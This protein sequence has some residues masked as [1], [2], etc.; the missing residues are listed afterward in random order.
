MKIYIRLLLFVSLLY[1]NSY[2]RYI[3]TTDE[4]FI[5][6]MQQEAID[7]NDDTVLVKYSDLTSCETQCRKTNECVAVDNKISKLLSNI[8][9]S[10]TEA[11]RTEFESINSSKTLIGLK[12]NTSNGT[13]AIPL[14]N[15]NGSQFT[16]PNQI[17]TQT[18]YNENSIIIK[19]EKANVYHYKVES[20]FSGTTITS[21][22]IENIKN[23][24]NSRITNSLGV[25]GFEINGEKII[26]NTPINNNSFKWSTSDDEI[27]VIDNN[28]NGYNLQ[29]ITDTN[30]GN[31]QYYIKYK[32]ANVQKNAFKNIQSDIKLIYRVY[33]DNPEYRIYVQ[34]TDKIYKQT[35]K[36]TS[37]LSGAVLQNEQLGFTG[38]YSLNG[39]TCPLF[40]ANT[41]IGGDVDTNIFSSTS[42]CN[43]NCFIQEACSSWTEN[44]KCIPTSFDKSHPV[45]DYTGKTIFTKYNISWDCDK[46][47][48]ISGECLESKTVVS[49]ANTNFDTS[50]IG[51][52]SEKFENS[53]ESLTKI[54]S[55]EQ[56][57][58][59]WSGWAGYCEDG[60]MID[61]SWM[62]DPVTIL[63]MAMMAYT[64]AL[65][66]GYGE[67][68]KAGAESVNSVFETAET[69]SKVAEGASN[70]SDVANAGKVVSSGFFNETLYEATSIGL[71]ISNGQALIAAASIAAAAMA[72]PV[73]DDMAMAND[74][75]MAQMGGNAKSM[76]AINFVQ[77]M[78]S[79]GLSY[80]NLMAYSINSSEVSMELKEPWEN[81]ISLSEEQLAGL[82]HATHENFV[83][84]SFLLESTDTS[85][86]ISIFTVTS[87]LAYQQAGQVICGNGRIAL[88]MNIS[89]QSGD[90]GGSAGQAMAMAAAG[91]AVSM[92]PPPWNLAGA[93]LLKVLESVSDGDACKDSDLAT[94]W[95]IE[96]FKTNKAIK[97]SQ[98]RYIK[99][100]CEEK[101]RW[102][103]CMRKRNHFC[104]YDQEMSRIFVEGA[105]VQLDKPWVKG[106]CDDISISD[107]KNISF[108]KCL[109]EEDPVVDQCFPS[110]SWDALN[111]AIK[112]Q[113][114]KGFDA[115]SL[116]NTAIDSMPV[117]EDP[118]G[119][120]E[121]D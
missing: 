77:C 16:F 87:G 21:L 119:E 23:T 29:L 51:W 106:G 95:G 58:R 61:N 9:T 74:Y 18:V 49:S 52:K 90:G 92:L 33:K 82:I 88:A 48:T 114:I 10:L 30:A 8:S 32:Y 55:S 72:D 105:K 103:A 96:Q 11:K 97:G 35:T 22:D 44:S 111:T 70:A 102:G 64:G 6:W 121:G 110:Y 112:K 83:R 50:S 31:T 28:S 76:A 20:L 91:A 53:D 43:D 65:Q 13:V 62:S 109:T 66:G 26:I 7:V 89:A 47:E 94:K 41:D 60:L 71:K 5:Q 93:V 85:T 2:G 19:T 104:C 108:R 3:C 57:G 54:V 39:S 38:I 79:I 17:G 40:D 73:D 120:R 27:T 14:N 46:S 113:T 1:I 15:F 107:L 63:S 80:P 36:W 56:M 116:T 98:C 37:L 118:W 59:V 115:E 67:T 84:G 25:V 86:G 24:V 12:I 81:S 42:T 4:P 69:G 101:Y 100:S 75:M 99:S 45:T 117:R 78:A 34:D 68:L